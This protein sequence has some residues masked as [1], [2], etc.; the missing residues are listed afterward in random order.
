ML[1]KREPRACDICRQRKV[2]CNVARIGVPCFNCSRASA[3]CSVSH[4]PARGKRSGEQ[5]SANIVPP[6][7]IY[8]FKVNFP[9][10]HSSPSDDLTAVPA[11]ESAQGSPKESRYHVTDIPPNDAEHISLPPIKHG[12]PEFIAPLPESIDQNVLRLLHESGAISI[13]PKSIVDELLR[14]F[15]CY[16][17]PLLP[18]VDLGSFIDAM[19]GTNENTISL[20]LFQ[21]VM[22]AGAA[23]ADL[24]HMQYVDFQSSTDNQRM[25]FERVKLLYE[26]D[27]ESNPTTMVQ[28]LLL[29][30]YW[31]SQLNDIKGRVY[32]LNIALSLA[33]GIG[34]HIPSHYSDQPEQ[35]RF[36]RRLWGC[37]I[38][39]SQLLSLTERRQV[40][41]PS[42]ATDCEVM[43]LDDWDDIALTRALT[44]YCPSGCDLDVSLVG[45]LFIQQVKLCVIISR[46]LES[47]YELS[48]VRRIDSSDAHMMLIP[49]AKA[50]SVAVVA[51]DQE[52]RE[53]YTETSSLTTAFGQDHRSNGAL[54][55][56]HSAALE[57]LYWTTLSAAH[58][59]HLLHEHHTDSATGALQEY[60]CLTV[61][62]AAR[63]VTEIGKTLEDSNL[64]QFL[65]P[66]AV[67]AF[68]VTSIQHLKD[69]MSTEPERRGTGSL[70][71]GQ[72]LQVFTALRKRYL[73][74][75]TAIDFIERVKR[76]R[77]FYHS[78]EWEERLRPATGAEGASIRHFAGEPESS[79]TAETR[80][81]PQLDMDT[82]D[83]RWS[84]QSGRATPRSFR[85]GNDLLDLAYL[86]V[87][88]LE[89]FSEVFFSSLV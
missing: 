60:S 81:L 65:P 40:S 20:L 41:P 36:R 74:V 6:A 88:N 10:T 78:V 77:V 16:V 3:T 25:F 7:N 33:C 67:G 54:L 45:R 5:G 59:P 80:S 22:M 39:R 57:M 82:A 50:P 21:A 13:P 89:G 55:G 64:V 34:L 29:I 70:Y 42:F 31:H 46:V 18:I 1:R 23:F 49:K 17:Y 63:R 79:R 72:T 48:G 12:L 26:L 56:V 61:Q 71:L 52:L 15:V 43:Q 87:P 2:R 66:L 69:A 62:S 30:T 85:D 73:S 68:I 24:S 58:R 47:Q 75:D 19:S 11:P 4:S 76:G 9:R 37:C 27:V 83:L 8:T 32:W 14:G 44:K 84:E 28:A 35:S 38:V 51:R 86:P 53:W